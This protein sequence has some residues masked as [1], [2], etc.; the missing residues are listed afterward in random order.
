MSTTT[1][2]GLRPDLALT[3]PLLSSSLTVFYAIMEGTVFYS[4]QQAAK[5]DPT[6]T[7]KVMRSWWNAFFAPGI[8]LIF[9]V[10]LPGIFGGTY[11]LRYFEQ[12]SLEWN[13]CLAGATFT[14][15]HFAFAPTIARVIY[16]IC[17]EKIEKQGK[18][19]ENVQ[20]WLNIHFWRVLLADL[21]ALVC[22]SVVFAGIAG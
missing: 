11:V 4:F 5:K 16:N 20:R 17:D 6:A 7:A 15:G 12:G 8:T 18:T 2:L 19:M 14:L 13:L 1:T 3:I 22:F 21:P 9:A 10:T